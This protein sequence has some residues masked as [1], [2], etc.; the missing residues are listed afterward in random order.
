MADIS[1]DAIPIFGK[2]FT[3][4]LGGIMGA[5]AFLKRYQTK[6][7]CKH[8]HSEHDERQNL[9]QKARDAKY[10]L[11]ENKIDNIQTVFEIEIKN[12]NEQQKKTHE[13][14][15]KIADKIFVVKS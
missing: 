5:L 13:L 14:V 3:G 1:L 8:S 2:V 10:K 7:G 6:A 12:S 9:R 11:L 15:E 4:I